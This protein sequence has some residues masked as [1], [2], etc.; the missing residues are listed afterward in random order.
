[1]MLTPTVRP[2]VVVVYEDG[3][4]QTIVSDTKLDWCIIDY[5]VEYNDGEPVKSPYGKDCFIS[6]IQQHENVESKFLPFKIDGE[7]HPSTNA[8]YVEYVFQKA[9]KKNA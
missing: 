2:R 8:G 9:M 7:E 3:V 4:V 5:D 6:S 1:M